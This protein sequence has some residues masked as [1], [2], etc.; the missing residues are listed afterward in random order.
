MRA[1]RVLAA[2]LLLG[3]LFGVMVGAGVIYT[4]FLYL[5]VL[6][7]VV[8]WIWTQF[9]LRG[10]S[11][12]RRARSLRASVGDIFEEYFELSNDSRMGK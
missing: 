7:I 8:S 9:S 3:G 6:I 11:V 10:L 4:R 5:G 2:I 12:R 1:G